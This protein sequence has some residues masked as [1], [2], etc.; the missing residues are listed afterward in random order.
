M[1]DQ[2][3][4]A[5]QIIKSTNAEIDDSLNDIEL[6]IDILKELAQ[7]ANEEVQKQ[8]NIIDNVYDNITDV[9][10]NVDGVNEDLKNAMG[11]AQRG[12][13]KLFCDV[14]CICLMIGLIVAL[15]KVSEGL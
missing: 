11:K 4:E 15:L 14:I 12:C 2:Q 6:G 7:N 5:L 1:K 10:D 9:Q 13:D 8:R 3:E